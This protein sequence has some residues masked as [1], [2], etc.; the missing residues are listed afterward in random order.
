MTNL[1]NKVI[2]V[3]SARIRDAL[4]VHV[5][6]DVD[7]QVSLVIRTTRRT[8]SLQKEIMAWSKGDCGSTTA[9]S[10]SATVSHTS[11][12]ANKGSQKHSQDDNHFMDPCNRIDM[13]RRL[14]YVS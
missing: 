4:I 6:I 7:A 3:N 14:K 13:R 8:S 12:P 11:P 2:E 5:N 9:A 10:K 1:E